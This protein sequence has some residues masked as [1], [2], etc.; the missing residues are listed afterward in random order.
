M[1]Y[2]L[3]VEGRARVNPGPATGRA[4]FVDLT[5]PHTDFVRGIAGRG[6]LNRTGFV[7]EVD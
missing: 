2:I 3:F 1:V 5:A 6:R 7:R 4:S